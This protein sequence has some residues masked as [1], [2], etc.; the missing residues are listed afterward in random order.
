[1]VMSVPCQKCWK[2]DR[3][4]GNMFAT[5]LQSGEPGLGYVELDPI[6]GKPYH[7]KCIH[8]HKYKLVPSGLFD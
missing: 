3:E 7:F 1:M 4:A 8:G 5:K 6:E 2:R